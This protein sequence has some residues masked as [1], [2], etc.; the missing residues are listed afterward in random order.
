MI[1]SDSSDCSRTESTGSRKFEKHPRSRHGSLVD[2]KVPAVVQ[3][4]AIAPQELQYLFTSDNY[5][6]RLFIMKG[7]IVSNETFIS[8]QHI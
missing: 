5:N 3:T 1:K 2:V 6:A 7:C 8:R 4:P